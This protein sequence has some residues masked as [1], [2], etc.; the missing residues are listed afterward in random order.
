M[1]RRST[2]RRAPRHAQACRNPE[3]LSFACDGLAAV[4]LM[5]GDLDEEAA[6]LAGASHGLRER[7]GIVPWPLLRPVITA[8][9]DGIRD[10]LP[11][12][13]FERGWRR[14]RR[15][16]LDRAAALTQRALAPQ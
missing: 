3:I 11:A 7:A 12:D 2:C 14:G 16:D 5:R 4:H 8:I 1:T 6:A 15:L 10:G 13:T 9:V